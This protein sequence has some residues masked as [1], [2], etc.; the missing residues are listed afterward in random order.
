MLIKYLELRPYQRL[1]TLHHITYTASGCSFSTV[2][3]INVIMIGIFF[4][5][6]VGGKLMYAN[7]QKPRAAV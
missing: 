3:K 6:S 5:K 7:A 2:G 1:V 4:C